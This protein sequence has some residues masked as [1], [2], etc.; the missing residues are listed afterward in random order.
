MFTFS[1]LGQSMHE[2]RVLKR[3][4]KYVGLFVVGLWIASV[5]YPVMHECAHAIVA[6]AVGAAVREVY[7]LVDPHVSCDLYR[8]NTIGGALIGWAGCVLPFLVAVLLR[9]HTFWIWYAVFVLRVI[10][11]FSC[12]LAGVSTLM[13]MCGKP[14]PEDDM[15][16]LLTLYPQCRGWCLLLAVALSVIG[17]V[18]LVRD[19]PFERCAAYFV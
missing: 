8:I 2:V 6:R 4:I 3:G 19:K 14:M 9:P 16:Q 18:V 17:M 1:S 7:V 12:L 5:A 15:T 13:Y 10:S 11:V